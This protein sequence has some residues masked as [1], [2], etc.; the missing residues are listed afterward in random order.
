MGEYT[1]PIL[2]S[3][4][5][6]CAQQRSSFQKLC[7]VQHRLAL[8]PTF[9]LKQGKAIWKRSKGAVLLFD[10][11]HGTNQNGLKLWCFVTLNTSPCRIICV[12]GRW[13]KFYMD[14]QKF[15]RFFSVIS[16]GFVYRFW[17]SNGSCN[18]RCMAKYY[19]ST[20]HIPF[21]EEFLGAHLSTILWQ[22]RQQCVADNLWLVVEAV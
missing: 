21:M 17:H 19:S 14:I 10:T 15:S 18:Q 3:K 4:K 8:P 5:L 6:C 7:Y 22:R 13:S 9:V 20:M 12:V 1:G 11:K 16:S 2:S